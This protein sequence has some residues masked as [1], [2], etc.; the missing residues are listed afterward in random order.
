MYVSILGH[1][2]S[3]SN[4]INLD[5]ISLWMDS[6]PHV[7]GERGFQQRPVVIS[8]DISTGKR[9]Y[10]EISSDDYKTA[11]YKQACFPI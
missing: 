10:G 2:V 1:K 9:V 8:P 3:M 11:T 4:F 5:N 7:K 6:L